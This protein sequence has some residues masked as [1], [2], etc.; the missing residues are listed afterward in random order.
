MEE[1][2]TGWDA[3]FWDIGGVLVAPDSIRRAHEEF[4]VSLVD[5]LS[6]DVS[7][8]DALETWRQ[9]VGDHFRERD[10]TE[11]A[12]AER[13]Y[14][15]GVA[16]VADQEV[17]KETWRPLFDWAFASEIEPE[18][19]ALSTVE[20]VAE[21][22]VHIGIV[23]DIDTRE[24]MDILSEFGLEDAVDSVVTSEKVGRTKPDP[25]MFEQALENA[26]ATP[27]RSLMVGDRYEHDIEGAAN[28]DIWTVAYGARS[29]PAVDFRVD[30]LSEVVD[31][32]DGNWEPTAPD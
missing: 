30:D 6:L 14:H 11:F 7:Q 32:V 17:P 25:S 4:I 23:S 15:L 16:A 29:G 24:A 19:N 13:G 20:A 18:P 28:M 31:I 5:E 12:L 3:I 21:R 9:S 10:G 1:L 2:P 8:T 22:D 27:R 26:S